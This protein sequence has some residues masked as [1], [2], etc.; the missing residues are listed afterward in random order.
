MIGFEFSLPEDLYNKDNKLNTLE[1][2][3]L[4]AFNRLRSNIE[5]IKNIIVNEFTVYNTKY[6]LKGIISF[7]FAGHY[8]DYFRKFR[9]GF[10]FTYKKFAII[11]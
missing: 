5:I 9:C 6:I 2:L 1:T 8:N 10:S 3:N 7:L 4:L 11:L